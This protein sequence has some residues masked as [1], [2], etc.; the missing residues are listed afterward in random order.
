M[1]LPDS[2]PRIG[3]AED[4]RVSV[5]ICT[6]EMPG[7]KEGTSQQSAEGGPQLQPFRVAPV[8]TRHRGR[9]I[10]RAEFLCVSLV[11][12]G[13]AA[14]A[15]GQPNITLKVA[16]LACPWRVAYHSDSR[17]GAGEQKWR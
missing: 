1:A 7:L 9:R 14:R 13:P 11:R 3:Q 16:P 5:R 10:R 12:K 17:F 15:S 2:T 4:D 8:E 6:L